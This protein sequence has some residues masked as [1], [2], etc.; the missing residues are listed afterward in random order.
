MKFL[1]LLLA[2][3]I[4][5]SATAQTLK[6]NELMQ[7]NVECIMDDIKEFPDSW[8]E[9]YNPTDA[10]INLKD[11]KIS[12]K[13][14]VKK[15]YQLPD[16]E[17]PAGGYV[18]VYCDKEEKGL[19]TNF[20]LES[21]KDGSLYLFKGGDVVDKLEKMA[22]MPAPDI[23]YGR[24]TD[25]SDEWGYQ[26]TPT[27][28]AANS[29]DICDGKHIL[30][31]PVFSE[32]GRVVSDHTP[33]NLVVSVPED[34]PEGAYIMFTTDGSE[35]MPSN[36]S[37]DHPKTVS[38]HISKTTA[39]RAKVCCN[40]WLSPMS[41]AQSYV[42][43]P[44]KMT[45]P[46]FSITTD[47]R[48]LNDKAIGL[49]ANNNSKADKKDH[50][51][52]RPMN[53][54]FF[55]AEGEASAIN[56]LGEFRIQG[57]QSRSNALKSMAFYANKRFDPD[58]KQFQYE[59]FPD[60]KP[61]VTKFK[62]FSL[63]DGGNDFGDLYFRDAI[64]QRTMAAHTDLDWMACHSAVVYINGQYMG[65]LNIR[66]RSNDG[67]VYSNYNGLE[68]IDLVEISHENV[69]GADQF[70]EEL[71]AGTSDFYDS[72]KAFYSEKGHTRAEYEQWLDVDEY[73]NV[74][75][76][77]LFYGNVDFPGNN[78]VFWRPNDDD[79]ESGL[80]KIWRAI[81]KDTDFGLGLYGR[82][83]DYNTINLIY[84]P[85]SDPGSSWA[86]SEQATRLFR[87]M[88]EDAEL[89]ALFLDKCCIFM[90]DFMNAKGTGEIIDLIKAEAMDEFVA[91]RAKYPTWGGNSR[92]EINNNF[93]KAKKWLAGYTESGWWGMTITY[94][95]RPD[96]FL[97]HL[98]AQWNLGTAIPVT[99]NK[100]VTDLPTDV[101]VNDIPLSAGV[102]D[103][104]FFPNRQLTITATA[105]E[106][107]MVKGWKVI[108][109][110]KAG[111]PQTQQ[112]DGSTL[113]LT[114]TNSQSI[115]IEAIL[116]DMTSV[117]ALSMDNGKWKMDNSVYDLQGRK[118]NGSRNA[119]LSK[120]ERSMFNV[121]RSMLKKGVY[122]VN[123]K[124]V[125]IK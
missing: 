83:N 50:D 32:P 61:G 11:Y 100:G 120:R 105:P 87:N 114:P 19:H 89:L 47:D 80:P 62:S 59:F 108:T 22:K 125:V 46:V 6:I 81:I 58:Q 9:L 49:F 124:K 72:F 67:N 2:T 38:I 5:G 60:Q 45:L 51:W 42:F 53:I 82:A 64:I 103:G 116:G 93:E 92:D 104:K 94:P 14:K 107:Q 23:A 85:E 95:S 75:I 84:H 31:A 73:L 48:Y 98:S 12:N 121:Q 117:D 110:P 36:A 101:T 1:S 111:S 41:T 76:A 43:H 79:T 74:M 78:L 71:K 77:N 33:I 99:I 30:G 27:P 24:K 8:V 70:L 118:V 17:V 13:D 52:R 39:V 113:M 44:R 102:F 40:G 18:L 28:G 112:Y 109:T 54:E 21:G 63:R 7:S 56:Q 4:G 29:G 35:P 69:N 57:G 37:V 34:A 16:R 3:L 119:T 123:G 96:N 115:A 122:I 20:R 97:S 25:G 91:H 55:P 68:D 10:A 65:M 66:E 90:G 86:F 15:A 88:M 26:L 106:G